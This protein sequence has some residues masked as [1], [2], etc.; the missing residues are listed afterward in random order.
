MNKNLNRN[1]NKISKTVAKSAYK[2]IKTAVTKGIDVVNEQNRKRKG[3]HSR[4][5]VSEDNC[6]VCPRCKAVINYD[7]NDDVIRC[8]YCGAT[9]KNK[10]SGLE[11]V[12]KYANDR[13]KEKNSLK[14]RKYE[15]EIELRKQQ[16]IQRIKE[17]KISLILLAIMG[18]IT[19]G[20]LIIGVSGSSK[21]HDANEKELTAIVEE[22][23][24]LIE[25]EDYDNALIKAA[26]LHE[27]SGYSSESEKKWDETRESLIALINEKK[28]QQVNNISVVDN[29]IVVTTEAAPVT[30]E[31]DSD[32]EQYQY[33]TEDTEETN[34]EEYVQVIADT[35]RIRSSASTD[36]NDNVIGKASEGEKYIKI[37]TENDWSKISFSGK[38]GYIKSE[39]LK[40]ISQEEFNRNVIDDVSQESEEKVEQTT[41]IQEDTDAI[42][43]Q[44][45]ALLEQQAALLAQQQQATEALV[46]QQALTQTSNSGS[47]SETWENAQLNADRTVYI[48][49]TGK[50]YHYDADCAGKNAITID[51]SK[52]TGGYGPCGTCVLR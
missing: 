46:L 31:V 21:K 17:K 2:G 18:V 37:G 33:D 40:N 51:L 20:G 5:V 28:E 45:T 13:S 39:F 9:F 27:D 43:Q 36:N 15:Q 25:K 26:L 35:V 16:N 48:T 29:N 42:A 12:I 23:Q 50:K 3:I 34:D 4:T 1:I 30:D 38:E 49:P 14:K 8:E 7:P 52:A 11:S 10:R 32:I 47:A 44:Q 24:I 41:A 6:Y 22:I 19:F